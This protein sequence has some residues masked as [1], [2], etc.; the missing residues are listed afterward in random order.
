MK[1]AKLSFPPLILFVC[2]FVAGT[3]GFL[4]V[5]PVLATT[6]TPAPEKPQNKP[7]PMMGIGAIG[8]IEPRSRVIGLSHDQGLE[9]A[10]IERVLVD[11]GQ[12]FTAGQDMIIFS[13]FE[14]R[15]SEIEIIKNRLESVEARRGVYEAEVEDARTNY[16]RQKSL[17]GTSAVS[18][19]TYDEARVRLLKAESTLKSHGFDVESVR[20]ELK[21]GEQRLKQSVV[22]AP[23]S[24]TVLKIHHRPGERVQGTTILD[25]ADLTQL[26]VVADVYEDDLSRVKVGQRANIILSGSDKTYSAVVREI[27]FLVQKNDLNDTDPLEDRDRRVVS[28]RLTLQDQAISDFR[29]QIYRQVYVKI[30]P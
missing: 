10:L 18:E 26:D 19:K 30:L 14:R 7:N 15:K 23:L 2:L 25:I 13:D 20:A 4:M 22:K 27:G 5:R 9:G 11:E 6:N 28:V 21:L 3:G 1:K 16:Q 24:G 29:N 8:Q 12:E 17:R